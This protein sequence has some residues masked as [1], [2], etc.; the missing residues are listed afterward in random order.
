MFKFDG[1]SY[2]INEGELEAVGAIVL[3]DGRM[4]RPCEV[5]ET[6]PPRLASVR[7]GQ[8]SEFGD[9]PGEGHEISLPM[10]EDG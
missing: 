5:V 9:K 2:R 4:V 8:W 10:I 3:P 1:K 6:Y 7:L